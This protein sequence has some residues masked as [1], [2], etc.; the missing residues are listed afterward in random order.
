ME[1]EVQNNYSLHFE[2]ETNGRYFADVLKM[3]FFQQSYFYFD[4]NFI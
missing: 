4:I 2:A 3:I 1:P